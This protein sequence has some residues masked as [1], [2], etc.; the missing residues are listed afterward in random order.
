MNALPT[1]RRLSL[2]GLAAVTLLLGACRAAPDMK[3]FSEATASLSGSIK[4]AGRTVADEMTTVTKP[5]PADQRAAAEKIRH[6]FETHWVERGKLADALTDYSVSLVDIFEAGEQ[7]K[8][9]ALALASSVSKLCA[10]V[11]AVL[12]P[13]A[14]GPVV[15]NGASKLFG[16]IA[17]DQAARTLGSGMRAMQDEIDAVVAALDADLLAIE[18]ALSDLRVEARATAE[19]VTVHGIIPRD[20][21][22]YVETRTAHLLA[23]RTAL[24]DASK[25]VAAIPVDDPGF[26][27]AAAR[28]RN[29]ALE[30][31]EA[32]ASI[33]SARD[34]IAPVYA[35][36][37]AAERRLN[38][39]IDLVRTLRGGLAEWAEAH[40]SLAE[41]ALERKRP[42]VEEL[43]QAA[44]DARELVQAL[45]AP[46]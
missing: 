22:T 19:E 25:A 4:A 35:D 13:V 10:A 16:R 34:R 9:S 2:L 12:P 21:R 8:E 40:G 32:E 30:V 33:A 38:M 7:G 1:M 41:A 15:L 46:R 17:Q 5:W 31:A 42:S 28:R 36:I 3:P 27:K 14:A 29:L 45:R 39:E 24:D 23:L 26:E 44:T 18:N 37:A 6:D 11:G 20:E 43:V